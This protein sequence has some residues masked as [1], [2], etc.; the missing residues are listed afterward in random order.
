[1]KKYISTK[2]ASQI[3]GISTVAVFKRIKNG[4]IPAQKVGRNY[5]INP[6]DIGLKNAEVSK[7]VK[8]RIENAV[9][10]VIEEYGEAL[11]K[12]GRE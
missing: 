12:L 7:E 10:K 1:M 8:D 11:K 2:E 4:S 3:L 6:G 5:V 9:E